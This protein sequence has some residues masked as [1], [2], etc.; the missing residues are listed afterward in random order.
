MECSSIQLLSAYFTDISW[1]QLLLKVFG[2]ACNGSRLG[3]PWITDFN[4][5]IFPMW[6][7]WNSRSNYSLFDPLTLTYSYRVLNWRS[8]W[9]RLQKVKSNSC[10]N[11][12]MAWFD[13]KAFKE[14]AVVQDYTILPRVWECCYSQHNHISKNALMLQCTHKHGT[15]KDDEKM[16]CMHM[17]L[18]AH[19]MWHFMF[20]SLLSARAWLYAI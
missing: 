4:V 16:N 14:T 10:S 13:F 6:N 9:R 15:L 18:M 20:V 8:L 2:R 5:Q 12:W 17:S 19:V 7:E 3:F 11:R 1:F